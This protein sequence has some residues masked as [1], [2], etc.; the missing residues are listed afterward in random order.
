MTSRLLLLLNRSLHAAARWAGSPQKRHCSGNVQSDRKCPISPQLKQ[1]LEVGDF[2]GGAN[3]PTWVSA[4][5][6]KTR[7]CGGAIGGCAQPGSHPQ[8]H[9]R[10]H[11]LRP[12]S[13][14][15]SS[16]SSSRYGRMGNGMGQ[17]LL[18]AQRKTLLPKFESHWG[19]NLGFSLTSVLEKGHQVCLAP[20]NKR[21]GSAVFSF[22]NN[23][24][25]E[26]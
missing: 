11:L 12:S 21:L 24:S 3:T 5:P 25:I 18:A 7:P 2:S 26:M 1:M 23:R 9:L 20:K 16:S 17:L 6:S 22:L 13:S 8:H 14:S 19:L 4:R 10:H 15:A